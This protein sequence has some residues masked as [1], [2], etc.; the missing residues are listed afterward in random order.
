MPSCV[1]QDLR[2]SSCRRSDCSH[3]SR[4]A[5][6]VSPVTVFTERQETGA[7]QVEHHLGNAAG[8]KH[9]DGGKAAGTVG[10]RVHQARN[11]P[12][13]LGP[14]LDGRRRSRA[15]Y[16]MAGRCSSR[17]VDPPKAA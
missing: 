14:I 13:D 16:A 17:F 8:Q 4:H 2:R 6:S 7:A 11:L 1:R 12:V 9:L 5:S 15:E 10:Q 3:Q